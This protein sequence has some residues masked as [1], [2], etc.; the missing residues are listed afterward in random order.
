MRN[1]DGGQAHRI[2]ELAD[3]A[4]DGSQRNRVESGKRLVIHHQFGIERDGPCQCHAPCHSAR[5]FTGHQVAGA[6]QAHSM[7]LHEDDVTD[8]AFRQQRV[9]AQ[10]KRHV[11]KHAHVGKQRTELEQHAHAT[12]GRVDLTVR[13]GPHVLPVKQHLPLRRLLQPPDQAQHRGLAAARRAHDGRNLAAGHQQG[14]AL[15]HR[16]RARAVPE[17]HIAQLH[18][19]LGLIT[20]RRQ[21][22]C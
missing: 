6:P 17:L 15:K 14:K 7:E 13:K 11:V 8:H 5:N 1:D 21:D 16:T 22:N 20:Q 18:Q 9:L 2:V 12:A 4:G 10:R 19:R 3:Q